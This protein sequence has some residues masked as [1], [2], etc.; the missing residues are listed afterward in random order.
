MVESNDPSREADVLLWRNRSLHNP[1]GRK[2]RNALHHLWVPA[3]KSP[4]K[5]MP[6]IG[7]GSISSGLQPDALTI[8]ATSAYSA[9]DR[10][11]TCDASLF[12]RTLYLLSY[13][14]IVGWVEFESTYCE[15]PYD[16]LMM[17][18]GFT[19]RCRYQ[20]KISGFGR[21]RTYKPR[22]E[23]LYRHPSQPLL[24]ESKLSWHPELNGN[25]HGFSVAKWP[26]LPCQVIVG[27]EGFEPPRIQLRRIWVTARR[28]TIAQYTRIQ[29]KKAPTIRWEL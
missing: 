18:S 26:I 5:F 2:I 17:Q 6:T 14:G 24:N 9:K 29:N 25:L 23:M 19:V 12:G 4:L 8:Y 16:N 1:F 22:R 15:S 20:P 21:G 7:I 11:W 28:A 13:L 10:N 27:A 3:H